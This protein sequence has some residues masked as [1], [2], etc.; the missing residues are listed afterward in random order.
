MDNLKIFIPVIFLWALFFVAEPIQAKTCNI[1]CLRY[2]PVCGVNGK[3]YGCGFPESQCNGVKIAYAGACKTDVCALSD[4]KSRKL[5]ATLIEKETFEKYLKNNISQL[6]PK[7][8][9]LGGTFYITKIVW[10][11]NRVALVYYED[12][13]IALTAKT[14]IAVTYK[15]GVIARVKADYFKILKL[16]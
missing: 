5:C 15:K 8:A 2:D 9:V 14:K 4:L 13:H 1:N 6:S 10:Q 11:P 16:N 7:K 12:G 3:T